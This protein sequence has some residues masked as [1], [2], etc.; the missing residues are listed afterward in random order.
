MLKTLNYLLSDEE[1]KLVIEIAHDRAYSKEGEWKQPGYHKE[2]SDRAYPGEIGIRT[3]LAYSKL[4]GLPM[5]MAIYRYHGD[6]YDFGTKDMP[7]ELKTSTHIGNDVELKVKQDEYEKKIS[8]IYI[9]AQIN[10]NNMNLV[11]FLGCISREK[12]DRI[13]YEKQYFE[14]GP[15]NWVCQATDL[16]P[17]LPYYKDGK[18]FRIDFDTKKHILTIMPKQIFILPNNIQ[19]DQAQLCTTCDSKL[20]MNAKMAGRDQ[21]FSCYEEHRG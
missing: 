18:W 9:G 10:K 20:D 17:F 21:C 5:N 13:K 14:N 7:I 12:L 11:K 3:E 19:S 15:L 4:T 1:E 16:Q 6:P 8:L 2:R